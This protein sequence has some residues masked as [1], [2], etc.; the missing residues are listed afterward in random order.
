MRA[1]EYQELAMRTSPEGHDRVLNGCLGLMGEAGEIVDL[2]KKWR[3]QSVEGTLF[4]VEK[5]VEE[6]GDVLWYC[7]ELLQGLGDDVG[8]LWKSTYAHIVPR[9][10]IPSADKAAA[11]IARAAVK[12]YNIMYEVPGSE[13][14]RRHR[15]IEM[16]GEVMYAVYEL[17]RFH[18]ATNL[19]NTMARN[20][21]KLRKRYPDGFDPERSMNRDK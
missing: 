6:C 18:C 10:N 14:F 2:V 20:L 7:A 1:E 3:F 8:R 12:P 19:E 9:A 13:R 5:I 21:G 17:L 16:V 15:T 11:R 4:P